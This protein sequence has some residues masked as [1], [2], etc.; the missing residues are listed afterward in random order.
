MR[1]RQCKTPKKDKRRARGQRR[2]RK[3]RQYTNQSEK[4]KLGEPYID[5]K[6]EQTLYSAT[7]PFKKNSCVDTLCDMTRVSTHEVT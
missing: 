6:V 3:Y 2:R 5:L 7:V 4:T 1:G